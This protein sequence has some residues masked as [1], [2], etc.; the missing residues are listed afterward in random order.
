[1]LQSRFRPNTIFIDLDGTIID[2]SDRHYEVYKSVAGQFI[3][4]NMLSKNEYWK[5]RCSGM[6]FV[7]VVQEAHGISNAASLERRYLSLI[8]QPR[9]LNLDHKFE[10]AGD[11]IEKLK[12]NCNIVLVTLRHN[13]RNLYWQL[14][15]LNLD[16]IFDEILSGCNT[17]SDAKVIKERLIKNSL[18]KFAT[19][20]MVGDTEVDI[21]S[22]RAAGC[23][24]IAVCSGIRKCGYL[25][26]SFPDYLIN[27][28]FELPDIINRA[29]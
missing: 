4:K 11:I 22:G 5:K 3:T 10:G 27:N 12:N 2:I 21:Q 17:G 15:Q 26:K 9:F 28:I 13:R 25:K 14:R 8:E 19:K 20:Y 18:F 7:K 24:T 16:K 23:I 6:S 29:R 1:M